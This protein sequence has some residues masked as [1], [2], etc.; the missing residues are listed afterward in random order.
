MAEKNQHKQKPLALTLKDREDELIDASAAEAEKRILAGTASDSL[1]IHFL[2]LGT[3]K[4][5]LE[6]K[7]LEAEVALAE[8]K[9]E[10][11]DQAR[12]TEEL[13]TEAIKA[14]RVY[15]GQGYSEEE[16]YED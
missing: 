8:S 9:K 15:T 7:K 10:Q 3:T 5:E 11:I 2:R 4:N 13:Y 6:K 14:M 1:L 16:D 12:K